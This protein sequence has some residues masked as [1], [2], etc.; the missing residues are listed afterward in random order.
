MKRSESYSLA[1]L[2][3]LLNIIIFMPPTL[4]LSDICFYFFL[5][6]AANSDSRWK[7]ILDRCRFYLSNYNNVEASSFIPY[8]IPSVFEIKERSLC[9]TGQN[10][11]VIDVFK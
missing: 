2:R 1:S 9:K 10:L 8:W 5:N 7:I 4:R 3:V 6:F 11:N